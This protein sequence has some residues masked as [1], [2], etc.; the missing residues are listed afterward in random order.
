MEIGRAES[1]LEAAAV[2]QDVFPGVPFGEAK[3]E[4]FFAVLIGNT[5]RLGT[6]AVDEPRE[7]GDRWHLEDS[8]AAHFTLV[9]GSFEAGAGV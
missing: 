1:G 5:A 2:F 7:F 8:N 6:E 3:I 4:D 9:P